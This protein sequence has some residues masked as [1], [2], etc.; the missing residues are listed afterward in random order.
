MT[1]PYE[2]PEVTVLGTVAEV[3]QKH[4]EYF[5]FGHATEGSPVAPG[6]GPGVTFS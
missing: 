5:D 3:T 2:T 4:G 1:K 6:P